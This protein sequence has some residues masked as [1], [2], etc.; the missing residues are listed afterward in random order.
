MVETPKEMGHTTD[1][2]NNPEAIQLQLKYLTAV[3]DAFYRIGA[4]IAKAECHC[5]TSSRNT[6]S[7]CKLVTVFANQRHSLFKLKQENTDNG[8]S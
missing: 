6:C 8:K 2:P 4:E 3:E 5:G 1:V 7:R